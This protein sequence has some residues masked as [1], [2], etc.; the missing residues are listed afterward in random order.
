ME[1]KKAFGLVLKQA[2]T[3]KTLSQEQLASL[4]NLDRTYISLMERGIRN[5][6]L[7][8]IF[9]IAFALELMPSELVTKTEK[10]LNK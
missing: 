7:E 2:R 4:S 1:V 9:A 3:E 5:P 8:T 6:T 10:I